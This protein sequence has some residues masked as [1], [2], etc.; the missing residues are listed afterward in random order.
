M[1][2]LKMSNSSVKVECFRIPTNESTPAERLG[3]LLLK[4]KG[5]QT[6]NPNSNERV[7]N[8]YIVLII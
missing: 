6:I 3:Y 5:A 2:R 7:S 4:I 1:S 8:I